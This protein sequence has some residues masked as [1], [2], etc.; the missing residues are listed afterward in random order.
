MKIPEKLRQIDFLVERLG[1]PMMVAAFFAY[2]I[3]VR[4]AQVDKRMW[5]VIRYEKAIME[6]LHI[7]VPLEDGN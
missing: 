4:F 5:R 1:V 7:P 2:L 3:F 6:K